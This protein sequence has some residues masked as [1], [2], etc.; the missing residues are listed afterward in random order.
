MRKAIIFYRH[1][2]VVNYVANSLH[3]FLQELMEP[4]SKVLNHVMAAPFRLNTN[5]LNFMKLLAW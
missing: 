2:H 5:S 3:N 1:F 4:F